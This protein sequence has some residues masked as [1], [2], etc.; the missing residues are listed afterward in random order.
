PGCPASGTAP[1][2]YG[3]SMT[4]APLASTPLADGFRMPGECEP[5]AG[6]W[7]AWPR[8]PDNW[9]AGADPARDA[10]PAVARGVAASEPVTIGAP[11]RRR[12]R[13]PTPRRDRGGGG[14]PG[15]RRV[16]ARHRPHL[17]GRRLR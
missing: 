5:H 15:R 9:R 16:D 6:T 13:A 12:R 8:R 3:R 11:R 17:R 14:D 7:M 10:V 2:R 4:P 1:A